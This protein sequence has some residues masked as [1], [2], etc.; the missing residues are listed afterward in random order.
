MSDIPC[1]FTA[2]VSDLYR[3]WETGE[4]RAASGRFPHQDVFDLANSGEIALTGTVEVK[5]FLAKKS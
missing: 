1:R 3:Q 4:A 2:A 5:V